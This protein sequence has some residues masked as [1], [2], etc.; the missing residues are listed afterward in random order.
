MT[1]EATRALLVD[2]NNYARYPTLAIGYL[3]AALRSGGIEVDVL[4]PLSHGV[5]AVE[6][7]HRESAW[8]QVQR[9]VFF[10]THPAT[11]AA[12][13]RI[14][15]VRARR[16]TKPHPKVLEETA[17][18]L[19]ERRPDVLLLSAYLEQR[20]SVEALASLAAE[21]GVPVILG[22]PV[23]N[24]PQVAEAWIGIAGLTAIVGAEVDLSLADLVR[25]AV[26]GGDLTQHP[27]VLLPDGRT[28]PP[29]PPLQD[30]GALPVPD[31]S[32]F[33]WDHY[34]VRVIPAMTG[35]GCSWGKCLFCSDVI[36]ANGRGYRSRPV[37]AVLDEIERQ[38]QA[39]RSRDFIFL[40]IK[41]NSD[42]G[43]WRG[44]IDGFQGRVP[45][46]RWIGT[47]HVAAKGENGLTKDELQAA[48][49]SGL[50]RTTFGLESG[51]Q[52]LNDAIAKGTRVERTSQFVRDAHAAGI[53]VR[54]TAMLGYPGETPT[55]IAQS[56]AFFREHERFL[57]RVRLSRFAA[58]PGTRF[59]DRYQ[60]HPEQYTDLTHFE[61]AFGEARARY[62]YAPAAQ[63]AYRRRKTE[64]LNIVHR[65]NSRPLRT[66]AEAFDG[67]M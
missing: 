5:P 57:D 17:H 67:L 29:A 43:M 66:G 41:L 30:L 40:D 31:F 63:R 50:T 12:H 23:F 4:T 46:G 13:E 9:R 52:R 26:D 25:T 20:P 15:S 60:R 27:G 36:T 14:R 45:G 21:R 59:H 2:L 32:D 34:P 19:D 39:H 64:L 65:I 6:R 38:A 49:A 16:V 35:R 47:L 48:A 61:W 28:G 18:M 44:L 42:L 11:V 51:S 8:D 53:S 55:D 58:I 62:R 33:P 24:L 1:N 3:V 7:E 22:G 56:I 10:S 54:T 37:D